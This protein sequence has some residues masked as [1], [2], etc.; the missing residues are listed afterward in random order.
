VADSPVT[1]L[2]IASFAIVRGIGALV[3]ETRNN[4]LFFL[5]GVFSDCYLIEIANQAF[6]TNC[7]LTVSWCP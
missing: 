5:F 4:T 1:P 7:V 6:V 2:A 3:D